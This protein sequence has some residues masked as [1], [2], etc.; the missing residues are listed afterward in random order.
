[1]D[2]CYLC[3]SP[4]GIGTVLENGDYLFAHRVECP[5]C[6]TYGISTGAILQLKAQPTARR[7]LSQRSKQC[8]ESD[9]KFLRIDGTMVDDADAEASVL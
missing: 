9:T 5:T 3:D 4:A 2:S 7:V 8:Y 1:M 6:L